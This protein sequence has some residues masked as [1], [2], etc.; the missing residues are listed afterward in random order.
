MKINVA[1]SGRSYHRAVA[2]PA[3]LELADHATVDDA[4]GQLRELLGGDMVPD[5]SLVAVGGEHLGTIQQ[6]AART[7]CEGDELVLISPVAGG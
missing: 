4:L 5:S 1:I 6:H 3:E 7:L 2:A